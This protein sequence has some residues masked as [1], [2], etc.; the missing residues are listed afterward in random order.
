[1]KWWSLIR[2]YSIEELH[3]IE[4]VK[5]LLIRIVISLKHFILADFY[6]VIFWCYYLGVS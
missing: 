2:F 6:Q 4:I 3:T 1:M 5:L